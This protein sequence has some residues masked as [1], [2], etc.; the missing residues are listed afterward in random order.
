M[1]FKK[2]FKKKGIILNGFCIKNRISSA[3]IEYFKQKFSDKHFYIFL[4]LSN[5]KLY[6][7]KIK[8]WTKQ[9]IELFISRDVPN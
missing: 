1:K 9:F 7:I 5:F 8:A 2:M 6:M 3:R 4:F